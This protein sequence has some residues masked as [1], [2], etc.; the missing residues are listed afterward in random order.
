[1]DKISQNISTVEV[2]QKI[3]AGKA[4]LKSLQMGYL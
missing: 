1:M 2:F 3:S 4:F